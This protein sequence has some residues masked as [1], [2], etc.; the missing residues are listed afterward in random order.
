MVAGANAVLYGMHVFLS[1]GENILLGGEGGGELCL[2]G[3]PRVPHQTQLPYIILSTGIPCCSL[4]EI[5]FGVA[6]FLVRGCSLLHPL[7]LGN[8]WYEPT[9][10]T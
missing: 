6:F 7:L 4:T 10:A 8:G 3:D 2:E 1:V 9:Y 5:S